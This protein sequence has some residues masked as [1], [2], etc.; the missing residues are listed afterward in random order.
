MILEGKLPNYEIA[1]RILMAIVIGGIIG[2][3][4]EYRKRPAGFRT[5]ILVCLGATI[6]SILQD[7]LRIYVIDYIAINPKSAEV[8]KLDLGR[9]GAQVVSG[10]GFLGAGS[11]MR[12]KGKAGGFTTAASIWVTG[13]LGLSIGWGFYNLA[14]ISMVGIIVVLVTLKRIEDYFNFE[15]KELKIEL[16]LKKAFPYKECLIKNF[17]ILKKLNIKIKS[18]NKNSEENSIEYIIIL[19][20]KIKKDEILEELSKYEHI[21]EIKII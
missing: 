6:V 4:R 3:E 8:I 15:K 21:L 1:I 19:D 10:I 20:K 16:K 2:Y 11:I 9:I 13:C 7:Q 18:V 5:H 14:F 12:D 17:D